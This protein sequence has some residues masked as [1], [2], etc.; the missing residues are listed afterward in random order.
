MR[1]N[2]W[3]IVILVIAAL[4]MFGGFKKLPDAARSIG[5]SLRI[6]KAETQGLV[7]D[8]SPSEDST[9]AKSKSS[10]DDQEPSASS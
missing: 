4:L 10:A 9:G 7:G 5:R 8:E 2:I 6:F 1:P 3:V